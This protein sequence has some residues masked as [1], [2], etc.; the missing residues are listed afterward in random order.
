MRTAP[1]VLHENGSVCA[2]CSLVNS[3]FKVSCGTSRSV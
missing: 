1:Y 3:A 2:A